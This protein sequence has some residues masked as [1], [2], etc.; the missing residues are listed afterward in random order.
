MSAGNA[1]GGNQRALVLALELDP[2]A[3]AEEAERLGQQLRREIAQLDVED[4][5]PAF[6]AA[7]PDGAKGGALDWGTLLVT[8]AAAGGVFTSVIALAQDWLNQH[9]SAQQIKMTIDGD[10]IVLGRASS[11]ERERLINAWVRRHSGD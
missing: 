7:A 1:A 11:Q 8:F 6:P 2:E 3:D 10:T 5:G 9:A 4:V